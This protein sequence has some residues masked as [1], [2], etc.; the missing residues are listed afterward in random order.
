MGEPDQWGEF[1]PYKGGKYHDL[2]NVGLLEGDWF[3]DE[4]GR[5]TLQQ[6]LEVLQ[7]EFVLAVTS[8]DKKDGEESM[9]SRRMYPLGRWLATPPYLLNRYVFGARSLLLE[10]RNLTRAV[11]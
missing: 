4:E 6:I 10:G 2:N 8:E 5:K 1:A 3:D 11:C 7:K 9:A